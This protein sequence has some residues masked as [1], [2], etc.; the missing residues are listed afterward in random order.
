MAGK[1]VIDPKTNILYIVS[2]SMV[3]SSNPCSPT[4]AN[5]FYQRLHAID[6]TTGK[7]LASPPI[8]IQATYP[9]TGDCT[10]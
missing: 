1:P 10:L 7:E 4:G 8:T 3:C 6:I 9:G 5:Q 2:K